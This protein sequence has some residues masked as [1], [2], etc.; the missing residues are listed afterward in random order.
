[1]FVANGLD[2]IIKAVLSS[3]KQLTCNTTLETT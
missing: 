1:M 3:L 2:F